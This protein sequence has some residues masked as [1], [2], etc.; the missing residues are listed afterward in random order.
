MH[1]CITEGSDVPLRIVVSIKVELERLSLNVE[2]LN[3]QLSKIEK[4]KSRAHIIVPKL[5]SAINL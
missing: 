4:G 2:R 1:T 5:R 3:A